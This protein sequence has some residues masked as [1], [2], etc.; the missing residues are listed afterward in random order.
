MSHADQCRLRISFIESGQ[1]AKKRQ[2]LAIQTFLSCSRKKDFLVEMLEIRGQSARILHFI[3][4]PW[5]F[6]LLLNIL[7]HDFDL[8]FL[9][10]NKL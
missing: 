3:P 2:P 6:R 5:P 8:F 9:P 4:G 7:S 1:E 10:L